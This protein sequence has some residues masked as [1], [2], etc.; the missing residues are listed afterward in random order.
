MYGGKQVTEDVFV[1][2]NLSCALLGCPA[3][4]SLGMV[5]RVNNVQSRVTCS[6]NF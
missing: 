1:V 2:Q 4:E 6:M 5:R 3:I